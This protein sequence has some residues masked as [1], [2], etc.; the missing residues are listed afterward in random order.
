ML[1]RYSNFTE[2]LTLF[3]IRAQNPGYFQDSLDKVE[4]PILTPVLNAQTRISELASPQADDA[5]FVCVIEIQ[6]SI[7]ILQAATRRAV[8]Q[9]GRLRAAI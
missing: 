5:S 6:D 1:T 4:V 9:V 7:E 2:R 8:R 3:P